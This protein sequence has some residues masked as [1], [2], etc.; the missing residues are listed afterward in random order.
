MRTQRGRGGMS[1]RVVC[2]WCGAT[3]RH[4]NF[5]E[6]RG[7]CLKCFTRMLAEHTSRHQQPDYGLKSSER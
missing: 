5:K 4:N 1:Y 7:M 2:T 6:S 3:I